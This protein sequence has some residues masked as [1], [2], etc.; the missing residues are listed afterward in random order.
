MMDEFF[1]TCLVFICVL[2]VAVL[3]LAIRLMN[4]E[5]ALSDMR[6]KI[7]KIE[8]VFF[9]LNLFHILHCTENHLF[10]GTE[11]TAFCESLSRSKPVKY[12]HFWYLFHGRVTASGSD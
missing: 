3:W 6:S 4:M 1:V 10:F 9:L 8:V 5:V 11:Q 12:R 2:V 7:A